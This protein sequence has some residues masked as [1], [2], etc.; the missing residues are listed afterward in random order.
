MVEGQPVPQAP[1]SACDL[2]R[3][4][5]AGR[6]LPDA[7]ADDGDEEVPFVV[8]PHAQRKRRE[9]SNGR[10][11]SSRRE[12]HDLLRVV[13]DE[14]VLEAVEEDDALLLPAHEPFDVLDEGAEVRRVHGLLPV[15]TAEPEDG[16]FLQPVSPPDLVRVQAGD[17]ERLDPA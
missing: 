8:Q 15:A 3:R 16:E 13:L 5:S 10:K 6:H 2:K 12:L 7:A 17:H 1:R 14:E 11:A 9:R 4:S